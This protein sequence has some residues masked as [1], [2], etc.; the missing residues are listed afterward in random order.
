MH[1]QAKRN[2]TGPHPNRAKA[3]LMAC[4]AKL[5]CVNKVTTSSAPKPYKDSGTATVAHESCV[6][7][8][9]HALVL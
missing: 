5:G 4:A 9:S 2:G 1:L 7:P 8:T 6:S 3:D